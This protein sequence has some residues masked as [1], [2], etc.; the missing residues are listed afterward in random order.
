VLVANT[1]SGIV[2]KDN[3]DLIKLSLLDM[4]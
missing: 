4:L 3:Q 2:C 1:L